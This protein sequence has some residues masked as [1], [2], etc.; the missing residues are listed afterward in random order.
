MVQERRESPRL[1]LSLDVV[2]NHHDQVIVGTLRDVSMNGAFIDADPDIM[3]YGGM[4]ELGFS[5]PA[6]GETK[7]FRLYATI[8]RVTQV[9]TAVSFGDVGREAFFNLVDMYTASAA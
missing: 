2:L 9:G 7:Y 1:P 8:R 4:V 5:V 3:P 6:K